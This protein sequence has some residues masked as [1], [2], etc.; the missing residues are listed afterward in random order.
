VGGQ[1]HH[2]A[3]NTRD[4]DASLLFYRDGL[5][6]EVMMDQRFEGDWSSLFGAHSSEL[7]S[8]FLGDPANADSGIVELVKFDDMR[9]VPELVDEPQVGFFLLSFMVGEVDAVLTRLQEL[10][11]G[12]EPHRIEHPAPDGSSVVMATVR[13]PNG[14][15]VELIGR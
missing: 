9:D 10:A 4:I 1:V 5:G 2:S 8:V 15:L 6:L 12:G 3:I 13:D 7:H 14:V 11:L